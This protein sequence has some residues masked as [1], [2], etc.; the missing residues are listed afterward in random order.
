M[1]ILGVDLTR[2]PAA[3]GP[4]RHTLVALDDAGRVAASRRVETLPALAAAMGQIVG[5]EPFLLAANV[6]VVV[7][8]RASRARPV[9]NLL[10]RRLG[11]RLPPG[12]RDAS[13]KGPTGI[14][15]EAL[16]AGLATAG[17]PCLPY[18]DRDR[19]QS[20]LAEAYAELSLKAL[21]W[22]GSSRAADDDAPGAEEFFRAQSPPAYRAARMPARS[23][24]ADQAAAVDL[25]LRVLGVPDGFD[26][27]PAR[28]DLARAGSAELVEQA[29]ALLDA[30]LLAGTARR[31]LDSPEASMFIG[32]A[33]SG[34]VILPADP[35]VRRMALS[36]S[37][38][39]GG[40]LFPHASLRESLGRHARLHSPDLLSVPGRPQRFEA[41]FDVSPRYEF[42]NVDEMLW[43]K[44]CRHLSGP[45]L[46]TEGLVELTV[47]LDGERPEAL[48][49]VRSRHRTLS[50]RYDSPTTWRVRV[51][52]RD[53]KTYPFE[54]MRAVYET[55]PTAG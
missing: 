24:W 31:Y 48:R 40:G 53:G 39:R 30:A 22:E 5:D 47:R 41:T 9:E 25:V 13:G 42:D 36:D 4:V 49:L 23:G 35:L 17:L 44:H 54:V 3:S 32:D 1:R 29:A 34:Y 11:F 26:L 51:P 37:R 10:R 55:L 27:E 6:P 46:P 50:F 38:P 7:S 14:A 45:R 2:E 15:G 28:R 16:I 33:E 21:L 52:T 18:P 12:G 19:R 8:A 20:G 43:W